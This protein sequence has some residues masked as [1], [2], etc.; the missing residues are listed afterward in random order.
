M[1][2]RM[3]RQ[4]FLLSYIFLTICSLLFTL[5]RKHVPGVPWPFVKH[6]YVM[7]A[8]FQ[9]YTTHNA[10]IMAYGRVISGE[11]QKIDIKEYYPHSRGERA[12]RVRMSSFSDKLAK[13]EELA[14][15]I[16]QDQNMQGK[17]FGALKLQWEKWPK[18]QYDFYGNYTPDQTEITE[19][20]H[21]FPW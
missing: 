9:N 13:Y 11:W 5:G 21:V 19:I 20:T 3:L 15:Y 2:I 12:I 18:S 1:L 17:S 4:A 6:F 8:P 7:M 16:L 10:E 14:E